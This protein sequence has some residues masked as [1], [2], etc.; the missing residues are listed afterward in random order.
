[1][2]L[3]CDGGGGD[4]VVVALML[5]IDVAVYRYVC[6]YVCHTNFSCE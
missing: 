4:V 3:L 6:V 5:L 2:V 1:M